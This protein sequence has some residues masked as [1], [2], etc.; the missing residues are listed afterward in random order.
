MKFDLPW[1]GTYVAEVS[2]SDAVAGERPGANGPEKFDSV[3]YVTTLTYV[4]A[5]GIAALPAGPAA[6]PNK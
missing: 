5:D 2:V 1:Q 3:S 4:K 6:A